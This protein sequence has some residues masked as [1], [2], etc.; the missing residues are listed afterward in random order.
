[1]ALAY[2]KTDVSSGFNPTQINANWTA[3]TTALTDGLSRSGNGP[4]AM[5]AVLD[6]G[7]NNIINGGIGNFTNVVVGGIDL[8]A[9]VA[10]AAASAA[11]ALTSENNAATSE[12]N[13]ATSETNAGASA[14]LASQWASL[15][16]ALVAATDYSAK[17]YAIG[18]F[19][20]GSVGSAKD[21]ATLTGTTVNA[22]E[23]SAREWARGTYNVGLANGGSARMWAT[24]AEDVLVDDTGYSAF[25]WAQK[26]MAIVGGVAGLVSSNDTTA[27]YLGNKLTAGRGLSWTEINDGA[28]EDLL[29]R[30]DTYLLIGYDTVPPTGVN[31][32][33]Y[34]GTSG[35]S[36]ARFM[37]STTGNGAS[38]GFWVG[39]NASE[40]AM[41]YNRENT[42]MLFY[43]N[44]DLKMTLTA[45]N[46]NL[47][48][49][50]T[51][52]AASYR[53]RCHDAATSGAQYI[54]FGNTTTGTLTSRGIVI[55][56]DAS[57]QM[58]LENH[59]NTDMIFHTNSS[60]RFKIDNTGDMWAGTSVAHQI[61]DTSTPTYFSQS[62]MPVVRD[63]FPSGGS[64]SINT[65]IGASWE[66]IGP[67]G[68]GATNTWTSMDDMPSSARF[69]ILRILVYVSGST[70]ATTYT[71][72]LN[73]RA[74]GDTNGASSEN[75]VGYTRFQ[76]ESGAAEMS[77]YT[78]DVI[79]PVDSNG[80][81]EMINTLTGASASSS[82]SMDFIGWL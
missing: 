66:S 20:R 4:N 41:L 38:D 78:H 59:E 7:T 52:D 47:L 15:T 18:T 21:W 16:G 39:I 2:T 75:R 70:T 45:A 25:H 13:A 51:A 77:A 67:T 80:V 57:E 28:N 37:N 49:D 29:I 56:M 27:D 68:A 64:F 22:T 36:F 61:Y 6:M 48:F 34:E 42:D 11:A 40:Q 74:N 63:E 19:T 76:N 65:L 46:G 5:A 31:L 17:E 12:S 44:N 32:N 35:Q 54:R 55:G 73:A 23:V 53:I 60:P 1:M 82:A 79:V 81:F 30:P 50:T 10:A 62:A 9:Q 43:N 33:V 8:T 72:E 71:Q 58:V 24:Q 69:V 14:T 26:A 3:I